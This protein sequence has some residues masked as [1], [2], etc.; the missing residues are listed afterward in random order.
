M[1][2]LLQ[3]LIVLAAAGGCA[4]YLI[5]GCL[6]ALR[7]RKSRLAG[8]GTCSGCATATPSTKSPAPRTVMVGLD[9]LVRTSKARK[10]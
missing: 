7:G 1:S 5:A 9:A 4:A 10:T 6:R 2:P 8:C 3:H